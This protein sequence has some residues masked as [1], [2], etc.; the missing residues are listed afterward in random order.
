MPSK[1]FTI[2]KALKFSATLSLASLLLACGGGGSGALPN[3][4]SIDD[5]GLAVAGAVVKGPVSGATVCV[6][7]LVSGNKGAKINVISR[8]GSNAQISNGCWITGADGAY[9]FALPTGSSGDYLVEATG[10][11]YCSNESEVSAGACSGGGSLQ[12]LGSSVLTS[13]VNLTPGGSTAQVYLTPF[14]TAAVSSLPGAYNFTSFQSRFTVLSGQLGLSGLLPS[15]PPTT[16]SVALL[17]SASQYISQGGSLATVIQSLSQGTSSYPSVTSTG[18]TTTGSFAPLSLANFASYSTANT[19]SFVAG[20]VGTHDVAI[21]RAPDTHPEWIG[22]GRLTVGFSNGVT[23]VQLATAAGEVISSWS[24]DTIL[25]HIITTGRLF[26]N[27]G[28]SSPVMTY[29]VTDFTSAGEITGSAGGL[30]QVAFRN[31]ILAYGPTPPTALAALA[32][33]YTG[34]QQANTCG[35]PGVTLTF[36]ANAIQMD[37]SLS[38]AC[39][40][41]TYSATWDGND[42]YIA[43]GSNG[44]TVIRIDEAKGGGSQPAGGFWI[45]TNGLT[46]SSMVVNAIVFGP[47]FDGSVQSDNLVKNGAL[48]TR[49]QLTNKRLKNVSPVYPVAIALTSGSS[50]PAPFSN[51]GNDQ[52]SFNSAGQLLYKGT[53]FD[54]ASAVDT[55]S[56]SDQKTFTYNR[57]DFPGPI[58]SGVS[59]TIRT[60]MSFVSGTWGRSSVMGNASGTLSTPP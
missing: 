36:T 35:S 34:P 28:G 24:Q 38:L 56:T 27:G 50:I 2:F 26:G 47:G 6:Y 14:S 54:Y 23:S 30:G 45:R 46:S 10:G 57:V 22:P 13:I 29:L 32:G 25:S 44:E 1:T 4:N 5:P 33:T 49:A 59:F 52:I 16:S 20:V 11:S 51:A 8:S 17:A 12:N 39:S 37:G 58:S 31:N 3:A 19:P 43:P 41:A 21:Y 60:D 53:T 40:T 48:P 18:T 7:S 9:R 42:D 55:P 15:S